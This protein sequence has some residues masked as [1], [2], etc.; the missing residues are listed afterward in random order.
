MTSS[1]QK[2]KTRSI[3]DQLICVPR[4]F[5]RSLRRNDSLVERAIRKDSNNERHDDALDE[6]VCGSLIVAA[7]FLRE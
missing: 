7:L 4:R 5:E 2:E 6:G 1:T 3:K